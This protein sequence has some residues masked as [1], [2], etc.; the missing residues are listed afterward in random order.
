MYKW[1]KESEVI[2]VEELRKSY[3]KLLKKYHPDNVGGSVEATQE[4]N[5][6]YEKIF[7]KLSR[8]SNT[9]NES[10][11]KEEK[12]EDQ[13][14]REVLNSIIHIDADIE[15][16]GSWIWVHGGYKYR[17][18]LKSIGFRFAPKKKSW[19]WHFGEYKRYHKRELTIDQIRMKYGSEKVKNK[20]RQFVL[21]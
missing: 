17:E 6:E 20:A 9:G 3:R 4:I 1:F 21:D 18:F 5:A 12:A 10:S 14:F 8:E 16:I 19:C 15:I 7:A 13:A 11:S 2:T